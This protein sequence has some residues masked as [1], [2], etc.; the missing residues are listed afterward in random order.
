MWLKIRKDILFMDTR[1]TTWMT[2]VRTIKGRPQSQSDRHSTGEMPRKLRVI[3]VI[4]IATPSLEAIGP[5]A[6]TAIQ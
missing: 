2:T 3:R 4:L 5:D 6:G 1:P